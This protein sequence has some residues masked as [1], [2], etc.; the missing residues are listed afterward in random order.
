MKNGILL[1]GIG[2][3]GILVLAMAKKQGAIKSFEQTKALKQG[4]VGDL[5]KALQKQLMGK[6][7]NAAK[8]IMESG[9]I[10]GIFGPGTE[11]ALMEATGKKEIRMPLDQ[12]IKYLQFVL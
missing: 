12:N 2:V 10:D 8:F 11:A 1:A 6:G 3:V 5:V 7:G 4:D 9:G